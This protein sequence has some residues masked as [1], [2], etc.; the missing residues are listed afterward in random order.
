MSN[1][2]S[3]QNVGLPAVLP[4]LPVTKD[5][6]LL[7]L[8]CRRRYTAAIYTTIAPAPEVKPTGG[9]TPATTAYVFHA[10]HWLVY[11]TIARAPE[12]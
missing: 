12:V 7:P 4:R 3:C 11:T 8:T 2:A 5:L 1:Q 10:A 9:K 6:Y